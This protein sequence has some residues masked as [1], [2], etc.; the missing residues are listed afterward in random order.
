MDNKLEMLVGNFAGGIEFFGSGAEV[1]PGW[2]E[3]SVNEIWINVYPN[4]AKNLINIESEYKII[5]VELYS[6]RGNLLN[7]INYRGQIKS[8]TF[9]VNYSA[10]IYFIIVI[11]ENGSLTNKLIIEN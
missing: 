2:K 9:K 7:A 6:I 11:T 1:L 10:G 4:P 3:I 5:R 8:D